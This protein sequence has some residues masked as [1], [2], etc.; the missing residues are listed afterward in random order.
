VIFQGEELFR[1][2]GPVGPF[3]AADRARLA[4]ERLQRLVSDPMFD[5]AL[6]SIVNGETTSDLVYAGQVL[7]VITDADS[8]AAGVPRPERARRALERVRST[9]VRVREER[10]AWNV[11][12]GR[13]V[14]AAATIALFVVLWLLGRARRWLRARIQSSDR[15]IRL[16]KA[17]IIG[18]DRLALLL[19][20][21]VLLGVV[22]LRL[23]AVVIWAAIVL[24][25]LPRR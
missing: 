8:Q 1:V 9:V 20:R 13:V 6:V 23:A 3:S 4:A 10:S 11:V 12:V 19:S 2:Y 22:A 17:E 5:P 18:R 15:A 16:Q 24:A 25:A 21:L 14:A 7:G